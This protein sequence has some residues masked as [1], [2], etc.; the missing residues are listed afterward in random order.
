MH[1]GTFGI[2]DTIGTDG[3]PCFISQVLQE[4]LELADIKHLNI[5]PYSHE[6]NGMVEREI[7]TLQEHLRAFLF[8]KEIKNKWSILLPLIQ[9]I[10]NASVHSAIQCCPAQLVFTD[11]VDLDRHI[12]HEP[13]ERDSVSL[14]KWH[15]DVV[16][17]QAY[18]IV[19]VQKLLKD[20]DDAHRKKRQRPGPITTYPVGS[21]VL[22]QHVNG[23][24]RPP[25]KTHLLWLGPY[26]VI[27]SRLRMLFTDVREL[28]ILKLHGPLTCTLTT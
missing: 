15:K 5:A 21:Y 1:A 14:P 25:T 24:G 22:V 27:K 7:R 9:W 12:I 16:E 8:D 13:L 28:Y 17:A 26:L 18:L 11:A 23:R 10:M 4:L 2:P 6:E 19:A 20:V 3:G